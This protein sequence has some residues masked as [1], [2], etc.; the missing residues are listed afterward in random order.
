MGQYRVHVHVCR[1]LLPRGAR[2]PPPPFS[3]RRQNCCRSLLCG[4]FLKL[5]KRACLVLGKGP[6]QVFATKLFSSQ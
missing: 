4:I 3:R 6:H 1:R 2:T 5:P